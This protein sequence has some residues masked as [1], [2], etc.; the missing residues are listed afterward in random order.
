MLGIGTNNKLLELLHS[1]DLVDKM[2]EAVK[3]KQLDVQYADKETAKL[4]QQVIDELSLLRTEIEELI[5]SFDNDMVEEVKAYLGKDVQRLI[6]DQNNL[7]S[8]TFST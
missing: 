5:K 3:E 7:F 2:L 6:N 1:L 4:Y 8:D